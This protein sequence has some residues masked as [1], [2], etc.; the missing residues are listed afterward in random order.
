VDPCRPTNSVKALK[1]IRILAGTAN[2]IKVIG[3][4]SQVVLKERGAGAD[5]HTARQ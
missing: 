2:K 5:K 1:A 4:G 3:K